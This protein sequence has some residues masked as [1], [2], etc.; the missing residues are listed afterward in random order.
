MIQRATFFKKAI[1]FRKRINFSVLTTFHRKKFWEE[2]FEN[3]KSLQVHN[4]RVDKATK[5]QMKLQHRLI[6]PYYEHV[7]SS[8]PQDSL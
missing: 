8:K 2:T 3:K 6:R 7:A 1:N 4:P 5:I